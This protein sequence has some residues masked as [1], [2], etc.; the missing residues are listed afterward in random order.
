[1][2]LPQLSRNFLVDRGLWCTGRL[3]LRCH[4]SVFP[5]MATKAPISSHRWQRWLILVWRR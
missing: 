5:V 4:T 3:R 1:M 2:F